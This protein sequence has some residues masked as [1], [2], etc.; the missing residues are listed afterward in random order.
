MDDFP[1]ASIPATVA[2]PYRGG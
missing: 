2:V 1:P